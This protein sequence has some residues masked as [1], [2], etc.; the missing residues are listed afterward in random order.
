MGDGGSMWVIANGAPKTGSTWPVQLL[1]ATGRSQRVP[2]ALQTPNWQNSSVREDIPREAVDRLA[3]SSTAYLSKQ[4]WHDEKREY[5]GIPGV[6]M[7]NSIRDL[8]DT[9]VSRYYHDVRLRKFAGSI[10]NI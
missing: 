2:G 4:H 8:R 7:L 9:F 6:K 5:L 1:N 10:E 3:T